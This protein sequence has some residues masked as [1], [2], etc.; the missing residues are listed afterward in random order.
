MDERTGG[1]LM[2][3]RDG[4]REQKVALNLRLFHKVSAKWERLWKESG[5]HGDKLRI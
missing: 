3:R 2:K 1:G 4:G 5:V